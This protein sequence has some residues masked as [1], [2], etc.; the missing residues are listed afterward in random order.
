[1][2]S[3]RPPLARITLPRRLPDLLRRERLLSFLH[4]NV[5]RKLI[6]VS[7]AAG[8]G[9]SSLVI[10]FAYETDLPVAWLR[11]DET[12]RDLAVLASDL[13][14]ALRQRFPAFESNLP[15]L[16]AQPGAQ[17]ADLGS[18]FA[19]EI[20]SGLDTYFVFVLDDYHITDGAEPVA[21]FFDALLAAL[22]EQAHLFITGRTI[23]SL[24]LAALTA[25]NQVAGLSEE[26]L[27][28][29]SEEVRALLEVRNHVTLP[30]AEA[31]ELVSRTEGW[32]TGILLTSQLMWRGLVANLMQADHG[33]G[34]LYKYLAAEVLDQQPAPLHHFLLESSVLPEM[35]PAAC[36]AVLE[37][38]DSAEMLQQVETRRL[39][40]TTVGDDFRAY[41]YHNL[42]R[43][44]L[45]SRLRAQAPERLKALQASAADWYAGRG[46]LEA[47][48]TFYL[49]AGHTRRAGE[50]AEAKAEPLYQAGRLATLQRWG[51]QL[52]A[53]A[54]ETPYLRMY[55]GKMASDASQPEQAHAELDLAASTFRS[56]SNVHG[57]LRVDLN[58]CWLL[59]RIG[60]YPQTLAL[61]QTCLPR[62]HALNKPVLAATALR[63]IADCQSAEGDLAAAGNTLLEA[64]SLLGAPE[65]W[66]DQAAALNNLAL[67][68]RQR[69]ELTAASQTQLASLKIWR[70]HNVPDMLAITCQCSR[71]RARYFA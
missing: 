4:E 6:L 24:S 41:Q 55:L 22:P 2:V 59:L 11:F 33:E 14:A 12:D 62:A 27:R 43:D 36:D 23:P 28:F 13:S 63:I 3:P 21:R 7:A 45:L 39:F 61:A 65:D 64:I 20:E 66:F 69:G 32:I 42:F 53:I 71:H 60:Q 47:A 50:I 10:D 40:V 5:Y 26:N 25:R 34:Q 37:R 56:M 58:R 1:M 31:G 35:E 46:M 19:R 68:L 57:S 8:Y 51:E 48:V 30:E 70:E 54:S 52:A 67:N 9:K 15:Q 16:A 38:S 44:F 18:A 29:T 49:L 17:P